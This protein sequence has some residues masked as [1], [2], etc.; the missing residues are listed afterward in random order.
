[1]S[2][3]VHFGDAEGTTTQLNP[4]E[5]DSYDYLIIGGGTAVSSSTQ[6]IF[7]HFNSQIGYLAQSTLL[8]SLTFHDPRAVLS[9][10]DLQNIYRTRR[11]S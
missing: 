6:A 1:M 2:A 9:P 4:S 7:D 3:E 8:Q 5:V 10:L 11:S